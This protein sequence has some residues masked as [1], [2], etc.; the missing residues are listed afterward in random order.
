MN[1]AAELNTRSLPNLTVAQLEYLLAA[2]EAP[3]WAEAAAGLGVTQS[4][5]SQGLRELQR[6]LGIDLF[7]RH[8]RRRIPLPQA[9]P[10]IE[11]AR[12][13]VTQT[14]DLMRWAQ[15]MRHGA[16][17]R[18]RLGMIDAAAVDHFGAQLRHHRE[19]HP[20]LDLHLTVAPSSQLVAALLR[21][22]LDLVVC[23]DP[24]HAELEITP[25]REEPLHAYAP[26]GTRPTDPRR[27]GPWVTFPAGS[28]TRTLIGEA[29]GRRGAA[30]TVV[31]ESHQPEVLREMVRLSMGWTVLPSVQAERQPGGLVP[32]ESE[33]LLTR[34][35]VAAR[36]HDAVP[37][38]AASLLLEE[39]RG[40]TD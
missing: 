28:L 39:L 25:L 16:A 27:W 7:E 35:L 40:V 11:H 32:V 23:V 38:P 12:R 6:R 14:H 13:V 17:G 24:S 4:A 30:F 5:L 10:V 9:A 15:T 21:G 1:S 8:G 22:D 19:H 34:Q 20:D 3:S 36:R 29:L 37:N 33:P 26:P 2:V 18:L 31:A